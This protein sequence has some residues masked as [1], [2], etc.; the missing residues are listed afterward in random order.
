MDES[1]QRTVLIGIAVVVLAVVVFVIWR[2][3]GPP[4]PT[5]PAGQ[6]LD[7]PFGSAG[8]ASQPPVL[9]NKPQSMP[10]I[11]PGIPPGMGRGPAV[12]P[13]GPRR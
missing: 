2:R 8:A 13:G 4:T 11:P 6:T 1:R 12:Q 5:I 7:N 10:G 3:S 9:Q